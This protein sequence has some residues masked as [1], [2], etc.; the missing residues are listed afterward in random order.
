[1]P[2]ISM[3]RV[4]PTESIKQFHIV[5]VKSFFECVSIWIRNDTRVFLSVENVLCVKLPHGGTKTLHA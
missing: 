1:M 2:F 4:N 5:K 3:R